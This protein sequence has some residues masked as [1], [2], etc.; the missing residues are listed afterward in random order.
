MI[1]EITKKTTR[2]QMVL[3]IKKLKSRKVFK[4]SK[5]CGAI[6]W[7]EDGLEYQKRLRNEWE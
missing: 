4:S 1:I 2:E 7:R 6:P 5:Y 3:L